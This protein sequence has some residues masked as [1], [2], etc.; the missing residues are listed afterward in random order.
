MAQTPALAIPLPTPARPLAAARPRRKSA[1]KAV[2][3]ERAAGAGATAAG[4]SQRG[5]GPGSSDPGS[6]EPR[7][8]RRL[9]WLQGLGLLV[10]GLVVAIQ[11]VSGEGLWWQLARGRA[12]AQ[13][14]VSPSATLLSLETEGEADWLGGLPLFALYRIFGSSGLM[15]CRLALV[16]LLLI[17]ATRPLRKGDLL[18]AP[19]ILLTGTALVALSASLDP[20][21]RLFDLAGM[22]FTAWWCRAAFGP[23][24][25]ELASRRSASPVGGLLIVAMVFAV[26]ANLGAGVSAGL[27]ILLAAAICESFTARGGAAIAW[28]QGAT[29]LLAGAINPRGFVV[30]GDSLLVLFPRWLNPAFALEGTPWQPLLATSWGVAEAGFL[31]LTGLWIVDRWW[32]GRA[33]KRGGGVGLSADRWSSA[34]RVLPFLWV[35]SFAWASVQNLPLATTW[36]AVDLAWRWSHADRWRLAGNPRAKGR[37]G[38]AALATLL[39]LA[40]LPL[41]GLTQS[42]G[43]GISGSL[44]NRLLSLAL[45]GTEPYGTA[46]ADDLRSGGMLA[47][48]LPELPGGPPSGD[49]ERLQLQDI[50]WQA[51]RRG[52]LAQHRLLHDDL[53]RGRLMRYWRDDGS[54]GGYWL[55]LTA[56]NTT[57]LMVSDRH[58][59]LIA[60]LEPSMWKPLSLD[61]SVIPYAPAGDPAY[62]ER[63]LQ[64]LREREIVEYTDWQYR[65]PVSLGSEFDRD[66]FG[67]WPAAADPTEAVRQAEVFRAMGLH[68]AALRVLFVGRRA[69]PQQAAVQAAIRRS[70]VELADEEMIA[71]GKPSWFRFWASRYNVESNRLPPFTPPPQRGERVDRE[72]DAADLP[73]A[74]SDPADAVA[75]QVLESRLANYWQLGPQALLN[76]DWTSGHPQLLYAVLCAAMEAGQY[77]RAERVL[78]ALREQSL[79][80]ALRTLVEQRGRELH[81]PS[82]AGGPFLEGTR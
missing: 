18:A 44:D 66:R 54:A 42:F 7:S 72:E 1:K 63:L 60:G 40:G 31:I 57:L 59:G 20:L 37:A 69:L 29:A 52:R 6:S 28:L 11:P 65:F 27:G 61:S 62:V 12:V 68:Y 34:I 41:T 23:G 47:W 81:P 30:W 13:G 58:L 9:H 71:A 73:S 56:R 33:K 67:L 80:A 82:S 49:D 75:V 38:G 3:P 32:Q 76:D 16:G 43:W 35:E 22:L 48:L 78:V 79:D 19:S 74:S 21:P 24:G 15:V 51:V 70:Q 53:R 39:V 45:Q 77:E 46:W 17:A 8:R 10:L 2:P 36:L 50:T 14:A 5:G 25:A 26:W 55:P 64:V 4:G